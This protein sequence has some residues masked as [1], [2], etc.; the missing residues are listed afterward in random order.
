MI[1]TDETFG[2]KADEIAELSQVTKKLIHNYCSENNIANDKEKKLIFSVR[3]VT[4]GA[5]M[6]IN[7]GE[8]QNNND[9][10]DMIRNTIG[11]IFNSI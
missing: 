5:I 8:I 10:I 11:D 7:K 1:N 2:K 3:A 6:M 9:T 4:Y